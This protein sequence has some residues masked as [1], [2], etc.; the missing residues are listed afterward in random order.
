MSRPLAVLVALIASLP[1]S[2]DEV[3]L[4]NGSV[5]SGE[6]RESEGEVTVRFDLGTITFKRSEVRSITRSEDP[7]KE[8]ERRLAGA[9]D[10]AGRYE[11]AR[12]AREQ[13]LATRA[14]E[15]LRKLLELDPDHEGARRALGYERFEGSWLDG[16]AAMVA[17]GFVKHG[18]RW[19][20][21]E[22][23]EQMLA[24]EARL[25]IEEERRASAE[26]IAEAWRAVETA[27]LAVEREKLEALRDVPCWPFV[28]LPPRRHRHAHPAPPS[29]VAS[30]SFTPGA[31][32]SFPSLTPP[33]GVPQPSLTP[34]R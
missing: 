1:A 5:F 20:K 17:R 10:T 25:R 30:P 21:R 22:T 26:R 29:N 13:G 28:V 16:D 31:G 18:G 11:V 19:L 23:A 9:R 8:L 12:W 24:Q 27:R 4:R 6:V 15:I 2:A 3:V 7:I 34:A 32:V 14:N 33:P